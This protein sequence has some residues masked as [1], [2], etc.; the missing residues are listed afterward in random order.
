[1]TDGTTTYPARSRAHR[2]YTAGQW[3]LMAFGVIVGLLG[4]PLLF[5]G[6]YLI[7]LG[8]SA[9]YAIAGAGLIAAGILLFMGSMAGLWIYALTFLLSLVWGIA[10]VGFDGW[11]LIPWTV[12]PAILMIIALLF[13]PVLRSTG[14][15]VAQEEWAR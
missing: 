8:G 15:R 3:L 13:I 10:E 7:Y 2:S 1:M 11:A 5:G 9:Y 14:R 12:G 4:V 6:A